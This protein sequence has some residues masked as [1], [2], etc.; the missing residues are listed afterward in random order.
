[1]PATFHAP[2]RRELLVSSG[3]LFAWTAV[4]RIARAE[5]R[6]P[7]LLT[8]VLRGGLDGGLGTCQ[9]ETAEQKQSRDHEKKCLTHTM[10][11]SDKLQRLD[12]VAGPPRSCPR[13]GSDGPAVSTNLHR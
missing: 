3:V 11:V 10:S 5:G 2:T 9:G 4:P 7:R 12:N 13:R 6:D 1:M 8:I